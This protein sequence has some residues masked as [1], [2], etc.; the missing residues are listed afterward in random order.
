MRGFKERIRNNKYLK[1]LFVCS[2]WLF[3]GIIH[4][5]WTEK[6][7]KIFFTLLF[8]TI[9]FL[10][11]IIMLNLSLILNIIIAFFIA[12]S[13]NWVVN[14]N[15][16][17]NFIHRIKIGKT[18]KNESLNYI[19]DLA[20]R[21]DAEF[22]ILC[23]AAF[24]SMSR[25]E[26]KNNSDLDISF[27]RRRGFLN[28]IKALRFLTKEIRWANKNKIPLEA[29]LGDSIHFFKKRYKDNEYPVVI[30]DPESIIKNNYKV[31]LDIKAARILNKIS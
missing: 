19:E 12:H 5:D 30:Y 14:C 21:L 22:S 1:W 6:F 16:T 2:Y 28:S 24:G 27:I 25:G 17:G 4:A 20:A 29:Y 15:I 18:N 26:F 23:A 9:F 7:Y 11:S 13:L 10:L 31:Y 3:Q 8:T